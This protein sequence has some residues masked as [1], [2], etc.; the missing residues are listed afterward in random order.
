MAGE[1]LKVA[2]CDVIVCGDLIGGVL[3]L[4]LGVIYFYVIFPWDVCWVIGSFRFWDASLD[5]SESSVYVYSIAFMNR[6]LLAL[7]MVFRQFLIVLE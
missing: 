5:C 2:S 3:L 7:K 1:I 4:L 6:N